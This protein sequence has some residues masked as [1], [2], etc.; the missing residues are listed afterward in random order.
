M[1]NAPSEK[2]VL[3][4]DVKRYYTF[5]RAQV[6]KLKYFLVEYILDKS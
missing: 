5:S 2:A 1:G 3:S 4:P 6:A